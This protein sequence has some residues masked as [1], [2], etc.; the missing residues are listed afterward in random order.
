[1]AAPRIE[2]SEELSKRWDIWAAIWE[3]HYEPMT[4]ITTHSLLNYLNLSKATSIL[5]IACGSGAGSRL[6]NFL[7]PKQAKL[8]S[9]DLSE[10]MVQRAIKKIDDPSVKVLVGDAENLTFP[11]GS[12]DRCYAAYCL[13]LVSDP[14]KMLREVHRVLKPGSIAAFSVW[15][16]KEN[17]PQMTI[18]NDIASSMGVS[19]VSAFATRTPFHLGQDTEALRQ[20]AANAGFSKS[21]AFY[22]AQPAHSLDAEVLLTKLLVPPQT[23]EAFSKLTEEQQKELRVKAIAALEQIIGS[24]KPLGMEA[25]ILIV[26][27]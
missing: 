2:T 5:E 12:F 3:Q 7:K 18:L 25:L 22:Q 26:T 20:R 6:C 9:I 11:D 1:M 10:G 27:K 23:T 19:L 24:G 4:L 21:V 15:G 13:H 8:T 14:D 17:C 16:R